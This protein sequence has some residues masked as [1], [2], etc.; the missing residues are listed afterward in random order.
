MPSF[1]NLYLDLEANG[2]VI[3]PQYTTND[4]ITHFRIISDDAMSQ[5]YDMKIVDA[6]GNEHIFA[7]NYINSTTFDWQ[8]ELGDYP[9]GQT[10]FQASIRDWVGNT[11]EL[12]PKS[13]LIYK[14]TV[15]HA[16]VS[17]SKDYDISLM[18][19]AP[20]KFLLTDEKRI[21]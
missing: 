17:D 10:T 1:L 8:I 18:D 19:N 13:F 15:L 6:L 20:Y 12:T 4:A 11:K 16:N 3:T 7:N 5:I 21:G 2:E 14:A 9:L